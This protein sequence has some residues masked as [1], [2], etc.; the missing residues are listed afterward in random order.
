MRMHANNANIIKIK[1]ASF[2]CIRVLALYYYY[3]IKLMKINKK[4]IICSLITFSICFFQILNIINVPSA[5][6]GSLWEAQEGMGN[7][8]QKFGENRNPTDIRTVT[9]NIIKIFL[10]F[11]GLIFLIMIIFAGFRWM[12]A[13]GNEQRVDDAKSQIKAATI[14]MVIVL[15]AFLITNFIVQRFDQNLSGSIWPR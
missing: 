5:Q 9:V 14:G 8:A 1:L 12:T 13:A 4:L 6:A 2:A 15:S 10:T 11:M 7:I 3:N